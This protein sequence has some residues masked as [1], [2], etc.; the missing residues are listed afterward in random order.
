M[1]ITDMGLVQA[2]M[3]ELF[4]LRLEH[5]FSN[6]DPD[7]AYLPPEHR[8]GTSTILTGYTEWCCHAEFPSLLVGTGKY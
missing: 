6:V 4:D 2:T 7:P 3:Q 5:C 1:K 8:C